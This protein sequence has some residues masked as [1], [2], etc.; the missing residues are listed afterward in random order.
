MQCSLI[1]SPR[2]PGGP[3]R[4]RLPSMVRSTPTSPSFTFASALVPPCPSPQGLCSQI[5]PNCW[6]FLFCTRTVPLPHGL[7]AASPHQ[8]D[9]VTLISHLLGILVHVCPGRTFLLFAW[10]LPVLTSLYVSLHCSDDC[11]QII[12]LTCPRVPQLL[13]PCTSTTGAC[14]T[15]CLCRGCSRC[16]V[17]VWGL[18]TECRKGWMARLRGETAKGVGDLKSHY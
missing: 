10:T 1:I 13:P 11:F 2:T 5:A 7:F 16:F 4:S 17:D 15:H 6:W 8:L 3:G 14:S 9:E 18:E 12:S